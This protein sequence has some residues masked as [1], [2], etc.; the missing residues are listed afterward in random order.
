MFNM[1]QVSRMPLRNSKDLRQ[2]R[3]SYF[4]IRVKISLYAEKLAEVLPQISQNIK[5]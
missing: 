1:A 3:W 5:I 4:Q 2:Y